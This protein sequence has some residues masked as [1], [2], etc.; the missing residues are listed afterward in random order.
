MQYLSIPQWGNT[1]K[2]LSPEAKAILMK[3]HDI[4]VVAKEAYIKWQDWCAMFNITR[5]A[6]F[7]YLQEL[8]RQGYLKR[9]SGGHGE[10]S[11]YLTDPF[12]PKRTQPMDNSVPTVGTSLVPPAGL[13]IS[14][15]EVKNRDIQKKE[16]FENLENVDLLKSEVLSTTTTVETEEPATMKVI[17][18][19]SRKT[20]NFLQNKAQA[21]PTDGGNTRIFPTPISTL[22]LE[23]LPD[24]WREVATRLDPNRNWDV[25]FEVFISYWDDRATNRGDRDAFKLDW[26]KTWRT[27]VAKEVASNPPQANQPAAAPVR[28]PRSAAGPKPATYAQ[29]E[30]EKTKAFMDELING[31]TQKVANSSGVIDV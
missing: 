5:S 4:C 23:A 26:K 28:K 30:R 19:N 27:W 15:E 22:N 25:V 17:N 12:P 14:K 20:T 31:K 24:D 11:R 21:E 9:L 6:F 29:Q 1:A 8:T 7:R 13:P 18:L 3:A 10:V 2:D 16:V